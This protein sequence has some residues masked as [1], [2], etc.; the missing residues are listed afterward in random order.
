[1]ISNIEIL[2]NDLKDIKML[3]NEF[4]IQYKNI[5]NFDE[6]GFQVDVEEKQKII[7]DKNTRIRRI[8]MKMLMIESIYHLKNSYLIHDETIDSFVIMKNQHHL[9]KF[10]FEENLLSISSLI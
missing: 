4:D 3:R 1:M 7:Y 10:Y 6:T 8:F 2:R 5:W 9:E